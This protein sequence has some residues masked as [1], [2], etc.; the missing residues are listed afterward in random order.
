MARQ[1]R[2]L[3]QPQPIKETSETTVLVKSSLLGDLAKATGEYE[4]DFPLSEN[5]QGSTSIQF[6]VLKISKELGVYVM[7][8]E[9]DPV[10]TFK[11]IILDY[12]ALNSYWKISADEG[13]LC[14]PPDCVSYDAFTISP[15]AK[16]PQAINCPKCRHNVYGSAKHG[17]G[18][19]CKNSKRLLLYIPGHVI[20][21]IINLPPT[22]IRSYESYM[23][24]LTDK[25]IHFAT[26]FTEFSLEHK[27]S[28]AG[29]DIQ[30]AG[31]RRCEMLPKEDLSII[32][33]LRKDYSHLFRKFQINREDIQEVSEEQSGKESTTASNDDI[34]F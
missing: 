12:H 5:T 8:H 4:A 27:K 10:T 1:Q 33:Q 34:P 7:P 20:P 29:L 25:K 13:G 19:A 11:S 16:E 21:N 30:M 14:S 17:A 26:C 6:P 3:E 22:S 31:F 28:K 24:A 23:V 32:S 9:G 2:N 18:K 15:E